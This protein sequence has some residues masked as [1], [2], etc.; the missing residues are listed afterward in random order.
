MKTMIKTKNAPPGLLPLAGR[1]WVFL[2]AMLISFACVSPAAAALPTVAVYAADYD[3]PN[4]VARLTA[5]GL[6]QQVDNLSPLCCGS[7]PTPTLATLQQYSAVLVWANHCF[8]NPTAL[9]NVLADYIDGGGVVVV[10]V[11]AL[12]PAGA[13]NKL[14]AGLRVG[15]IYP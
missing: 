1:V 2:L 6:F 4:T 10:S 5:T 14:V 15:V 8:N 9:G 7:D 12:H 13:C 11:F 3:I